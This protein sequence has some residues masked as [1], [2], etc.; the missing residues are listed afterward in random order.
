MASTTPVQHV[1]NSACET[2][3]LANCNCF[4]HGAGHQNDLVVRSATCADA[5]SLST[6]RQNL[7]GV[8]GG[9]HSDFRDVNTPTRGARKTPT[10]A[11][12]ARLSFRTRYGATWY[13]TLLVDEALHA[14]FVTVA[15]ASVTASQ[16]ARDAQALF[17]ENVTRAA[18]TI[19]GSQVAVTNVVESH[20]WC[21]IVAEYLGA[22]TPPVATDPHPRS[23]SNICYPR[24]S[25]GRQPSSLARVRTT[26]LQHIASAEAAAQ[27][28]PQPVRLDLLRLVGAATCPD[29]WRHAAVARF[30]LGPFVAANQW[31]SN[32][33]KLATN[34]E[35]SNLRLRWQRKNNW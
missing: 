29:V 5:T 18:I 16:S 14:A 13:E 23:Y 8:L 15:H 21:S 28:I 26:G 11:E 19:V 3:A 24:K 30:C 4:C 22:R 9:F 33:T 25:R 27:S 32:T 31:P 35:F 34:S 1:H 10:A 20:V 6:L 2:A 7:Q 12:A 17:I